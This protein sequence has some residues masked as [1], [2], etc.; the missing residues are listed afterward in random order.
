MDYVMLV[1]DRY[2]KSLYLKLSYNVANHYI[3]E[4]NEAQTILIWDH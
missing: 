4:A 2:R 1:K 3:T